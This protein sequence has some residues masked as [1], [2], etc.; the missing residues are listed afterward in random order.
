MTVPTA[1]RENVAALVPGAQQ[2]QPVIR[3]NVIEA[4]EDNLR[5]FAAQIAGLLD[6]D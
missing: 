2:W 3:G 6:E 5:A 1:A 4:E